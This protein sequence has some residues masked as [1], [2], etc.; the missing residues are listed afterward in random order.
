MTTYLFQVI[1]FQAIFLVVYHVLLRKE[2]FYTYNRIYLLATPVLAFILPFLK[3]DWLGNTVKVPNM[4]QQLPTVFIG[5]QP[6][7]TMSSEVILQSSSRPF[8]D[9]SMWI[10]L[11]YILGLSISGILLL[12]KYSSLNRFF[13]FKR[14]EDTSIITLPNSDAAFT[15]LNTIFIGEKLDETSKKQ[16]LVHETVH[17]K[18]RHG[19]DLMF[20]ELLKII[21]WFNPAVY[22]YQNYVS[23]LH[24]F[25]A[26]KKASA[27]AESK[28]Y[29]NQ[30][31]NTAFGTENI[32]FINTFF[33]HSLIKKRIVMLQKQSKT[34]SKFKYLLLV[35][36][37]AGMLTYVS[38]STD[39]G[40]EVE[41]QLT[42]EEQIADLRATLETKEKLTSKEYILLQKLKEDYKNNEE[43]TEGVVIEVVEEDTQQNKIIDFPFAVIE[44]VPVFPGCEGLDSNEARKK[45]MSDK[46]SSLVNKN[47]DTS[48][49]EKFG[50]TGVNRVYVRFKI[51]KNGS[52]TDIE[53]RAKVPEL[54]TEAI[55]T[56]KLLPQMRP[57]KQKGEN[58][59]VLYSLPIV[60]QVA[61]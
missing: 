56:L 30:L 24:E 57:G 41:N 46:I 61:E 8:I 52:V 33:N 37:F 53:S 32:S 19:L 5:E 38:C 15:F 42:L 35:P 12:K 48:L 14:K 26:D 18:E 51:D 60:F 7:A 50:L 58:V 22:L 21:L 54:E 36:L 47:F 3:M 43:V 25:I 29:Y 27:K 16:I 55:R 9:W 59:G 17:L 10:M 11:F 28:S 13:R 6:L 39:N 20:F 1:L 4:I 49:G 23:E 44:E 45:C 2:T 31:L 40:G 34:I